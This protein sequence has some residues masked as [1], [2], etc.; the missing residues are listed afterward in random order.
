MR[1]SKPYDNKNGFPFKILACKVF[2]KTANF[3]FEM[4]ND[5]ERSK[6]VSGHAGEAVSFN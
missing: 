5:I 4:P 6:N 3:P 2:L 1:L